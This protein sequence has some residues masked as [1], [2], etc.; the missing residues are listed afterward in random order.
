MALRK[1]E[2]DDDCKEEK[3]SSDAAATRGGKVVEEE[4]GA[5]DKAKCKPNRP[6]Q[7][8]ATESKGGAT[9]EEQ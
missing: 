7:C 2:K 9:K 4:E 1:A 6:F 5:V 8:N 3:L